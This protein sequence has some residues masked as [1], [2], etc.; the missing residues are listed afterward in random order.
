MPE[1]PLFPDTSTQPFMTHDAGSAVD[2]GDL[3]L[4]ARDAPLLMDVTP[5]ALGLE[6]AGGFCRQIIRRGAPIPAE[7]SRVFT[8]A[9]DLQSAV[10]IRICQGEHELFADNQALGEIVLDGLPLAP[11][12]GVQIDVAFQLG[13]DGT[14]DVRARDV[15]AQREQRIRIQLLGGMSPEEIA[16]LRAR[17]EKLARR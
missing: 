4:P 12:G 15:H 5:H 6:T 16:A 3:R 7:S 13:A 9:T 14:L 8:T 10:V 11:R 2:P 1:T 17:Q